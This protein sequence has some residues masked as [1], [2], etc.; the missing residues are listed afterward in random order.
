[1][2]QILSSIRKGCAYDICATTAFMDA[3]GTDVIIVCHRVQ[4]LVCSSSGT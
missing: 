1:M 3:Y 2:E 4:S